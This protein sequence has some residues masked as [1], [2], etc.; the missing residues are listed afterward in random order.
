[1]VTVQGWLR[2]PGHLWTPGENVLIYSPM[3]MLAMAMKI[4][5]ATF[6]QDD[7]TGTTTTLECVLPW[8]LGDTYA[9]KGQVPP[10]LPA[11]PQFSPSDT[12]DT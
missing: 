2:A 11:E 10:P 8:M 3:A 12:A 6:T 1:V 5:T 4:R 9:A 7:S